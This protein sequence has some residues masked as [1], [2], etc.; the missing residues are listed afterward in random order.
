MRHAPLVALLLAIPCSGMASA[1][2]FLANHNV[3]S[4]PRMTAGDFGCYIE[5]TFKVR[6]KKFNCGLKH[7]VNHGDPC[8]HPE[9]Y[10]EGPVFPNS[11]AS[12]IHPLVKSVNLRW[13]HGD[14]QAISLTFTKKLRRDDIAR[15]FAL[16]TA[17]SYPKEYPNI[18]TIDIQDCTR[19]GTCLEIQG[20]DH[21]GS[22]DMECP[23]QLKR[24]A[25]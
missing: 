21:I 5:M 3:L 17:F 6:D 4:W 19:D 12:R 9:T 22:G 23:P 15:I 2:A 1:D 14:L 11:V 20:F 7:Y 25:K 13:E 24:P 18:M 8:K 16:P 10:Q